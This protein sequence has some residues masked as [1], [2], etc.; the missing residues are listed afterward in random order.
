MLLQAIIPGFT[1]KTFFP[2]QDKEATK[3]AA[4]VIRE[5]HYGKALTSL[6]KKSYKAVPELL[7]IFDRFD[8][9]QIPIDVIQKS[10][11][12]AYNLLNSNQE[13]HLLHG[14]LHH[15]NILYD[16]NVG[17][18][19]IDPKGIIGE[20]AYEVSAF[21]NNPFPDLLAQ[22]NA[23][24]IITDRITI[25]SNILTINKQRLISWAYAK[26]VLAACWSLEDNQESWH[27]F[28][29]CAKLLDLIHP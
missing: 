20:L 6:D 9:N 17:W 29:K 25:F 16:N 4:Q 11:K 13:I 10:K 8:N 19:A 23:L 21:I 22:N 24:E 27:Y 3:Y 2:S 14:D 26:S 18:I 28:I 12:L 7:S 15:E 1:L 5:L